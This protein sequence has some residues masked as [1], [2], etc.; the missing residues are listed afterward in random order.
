MSGAA[1]RSKVS[2]S[3]SHKKSSMSPSP[4]SSKQALSG[5]RSFPATM[6]RTVEMARTASRYQGQG[7]VF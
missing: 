7:S 2:A 3:I 4:Y 1:D 6:K 5:K